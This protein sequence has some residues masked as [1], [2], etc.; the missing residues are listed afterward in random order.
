LPPPRELIVEYAQSLGVDLDFQHF[1]DELSSLATFY[2]VI[3]IARVDGAL[4]GCVALRRIDDAICEMKRL[5]VRPSFRQ[6]GLGR[7]LANRLI[8][9]ARTRGYKRMR[10]DTLP[11]MTSAM[12]LYES[13]GFADIAP[14]RYNP[15]AGSR[16]LELLL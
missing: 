4:A 6:Y 5:Y 12:S 7:K 10:L 2:E 8:D 1:D 11:S 9:E 13:L 16:W 15:I 14:Y 3:F